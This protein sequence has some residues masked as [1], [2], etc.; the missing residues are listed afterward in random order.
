M[1]RLSVRCFIGLG[2]SEGDGEG[3]GEGLGTHLATLKIGSGSQNFEE[4]SQSPQKRNSTK[5]R[6]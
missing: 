1:D 3:K 2:G 6:Q 5:D 4:K